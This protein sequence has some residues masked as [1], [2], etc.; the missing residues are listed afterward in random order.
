MGLANLFGNRTIHRLARGGRSVLLTMF[1]A[2]VV[3]ACGRSGSVTGDGAS[4]AN[5][6]WTTL[7][8]RQKSAGP[9]P[10]PVARSGAAWSDYNPAQKY[11]GTVTLPQQ[12]ITMPDGVKLAASI[13]LPAD[14]N[15]NPVNGPLPTVLVLTAYN[16]AVYD[17]VLG[18]NVDPYIVQ[19][20]YATVVV[21]SRGG[22]QSTGSWNAF[23]A[24]EQADYGRVMDWVSTQA[25]CNG[26]IGLFGASYMGITT[27]LAAAQNHPAVKAAFAVVPMGDAYRDVMFTGGQTNTVFIPYWLTLVTALGLIQP[28]LLTNTPQ[29]VEALIDHITSAV[30]Y[31]QVPTL[32]QAELGDPDTVYDGPFWQIRSPLE[33]DANIR[34]PTFIVGG[35][36]D[37]FQRGEPLAYEELKSHVTAKLLI[38][39]GTH[40][41]AIG[42]AGLPAD[43]IPQMNHIQLRWF[44][45]YVKGLNVGADKLPNVT[46]Y[47]NGYGHYATASDWP[48]PLARAQRF[49]FRGDKSLTVEAPSA[50]EPVNTVIQTPIEGL[51]SISTPQWL[52]GTIGLTT[53]PCFT[54]SNA[55]EIWDVKYETPP[56]EEDYYFNGPIQ[57]DVWMSTTAIDA[58]LSVRIDDVDSAGNAASLTNGIQ[59]AS[60]R[61]VDVSK[62]RTL[63][64][65]MIQPWHPFTQASVQAVGA[66]NV[67]MVP[68]E[69]FPTSAMIAKGHKLRVAVGTSD[70][71]QGVPPV[72]TLLQSLAG[73]LTIYNDAT[74]PSSV[75]MPVVPASAL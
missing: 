17:T 64:G 66:G 67:V 16:A 21:D 23:G 43:G 39:P 63:N 18:G 34:V 70:L 30:A 55:A 3:C 58:G 72:P 60:L 24:A 61:A 71:P 9:Q 37:I 49:Y 27:V 38:N 32:L 75:V 29:G 7:G 8:N 56:M 15:G 65:Q 1:V 47:V 4:G 10:T 41:D 59:T 62:S 19:H 69:V 42:G 36:H 33:T 45:Q 12:Y 68:V 73:V 51:C 6:P 11:P 50:V 46:Q 5:S 14:A 20:G 22:G 35:D 48:H 40:S 25:W 74:H 53:L 28:Q 31:F 44:D 52:A 57:V 26:R 13:T 2:A 54:D